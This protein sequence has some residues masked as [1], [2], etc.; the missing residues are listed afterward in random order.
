MAVDPTGERGTERGDLAHVFAPI[1]HPTVN[2]PDLVAV[3]AH[4]VSSRL[5]CLVIGCPQQV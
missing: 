5:R 4:E 3:L 1:S 2:V